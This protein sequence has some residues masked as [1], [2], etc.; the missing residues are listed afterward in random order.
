[1]GLIELVGPFIP[2]FVGFF[3]WCN[4]VGLHDGCE[5][6]MLETVS[7]QTGKL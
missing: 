1:M 4:M 2:V 3:S 6:Q 7:D 5:A